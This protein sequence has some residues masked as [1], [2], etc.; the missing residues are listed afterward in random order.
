[1]RVEGVEPPTFPIARFS[2]I[3]LSRLVKHFPSRQNLSCNMDHPAGD[4]ARDAENTRIALKGLGKGMDVFTT[5][6]GPADAGSRVSIP[7]LCDFAHEVRAK[8]TTLRA[9]MSDVLRGVDDFMD[10]VLIPPS[11]AGKREYVALVQDV[12]QVRIRVDEVLA[13]FSVA[14]SQPSAPQQAQAPKQAPTTRQN[15]APPQAQ[16]TQQDRAPRQLRARRRPSASQQPTGETAGEGS[17]AAL[18][19]ERRR[20]V[21]AKSGARSA[22]QGASPASPRPSSA[23]PAVNEFRRVTRGSAFRAINAANSTNPE[24]RVVSSSRYGTDLDARSTVPVQSIESADPPTYPSRRSR[25]TRRS[26]LPRLK[27]DPELSAPER[28]LSL[29][30]GQERSRSRSP[31]PKVRTQREVRRPSRYQDS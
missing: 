10:F 22:T 16:A 13:E 18:R 20:S 7:E 6:V 27:E 23:A 5:S 24:L 14:E 21:A 25:S 1:M 19:A 17:H 31:K 11:L 4:H 15:L 26:P 30:Q 8:I 3:L 2:V 9:N 28:S 29:E 12:R